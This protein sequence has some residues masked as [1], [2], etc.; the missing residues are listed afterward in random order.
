MPSDAATLQA[1]VRSLSHENEHLK[2]LV[3]KLQRMQFGRRSEVLDAEDTQSSLFLDGTITPPVTPLPQKSSEEP[4]RSKPSRRPLRAHLPREVEL[5]TVD[6]HHCP[7]CGG[8][9]RSIGEDVSEVLEYVPASF[10]VIRHVRPKLAC[11]GC[12]KLIQASAPERPIAGVW[13]VRGL[14]AQVMVSKYCDH[15]PLYRQSEIYARDGVELPRSTLADWVGASSQLLSPLVEALRRHTLAGQQLHA[16]DTPVPVLSPGKGWGQKQGACGPTFAT[17]AL[18]KAKRRRR[19]GLPTH[20]T[21]KGNIRSDTWPVIGV[22]SMR[23]VMRDLIGL[24]PKPAGGSRRPAGHTY[25]A[26]STRSTR[27]RRALWQRRRW[28][29]F[30]NCTVWRVQSGASRRMSAKALG[31]VVTD[32]SWM[33]CF[34]GCNRR[35]PRYRVSRQ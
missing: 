16:D 28:I 18:Q 27:R 33:S 31:A 22:R 29:I 1:L 17:N 15:L 25:A 34:S 3:A 24:A 30:D 8:Q 19:S 35:L 13:L 21:E 7:D 10:K 5:H 2:L 9:L 26:S 4:V 11:K 6:T 14:L 12:D 32:R 20:P 23:M